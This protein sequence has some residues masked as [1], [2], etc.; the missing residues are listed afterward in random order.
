MMEVVPQRLRPV[1]TEAQRFLL[2]AVLIGVFTGVT[3]VC[4]HSSIELIEWV[5]SDSTTGVVTRLLLPALGAALASF[6]V[7]Y[8]RA[9]AGSGI[10]Q[11][12]SA[13]YVSNGFI[14]FSAVP[15]KFVACVLSIGTGTP[16][17]PEDPALLMGAGIASRL[18]AT[19]G[20]TQRSMRMIAPVGAAAGI[21]AAF[22]TPITGVLFVMEEVMAGWDAAVMGSIVLAA[23]SSVVTTRMFLGESPLFRVP[24][25]AAIGTPREVLVCIALGVAAGIFATLY[26]RGVAL[27]RYRMGAFRLPVAVAPFLAGLAVGAVAMLVPEVLGTGYRAMDSALNNQYTW[28]TMATLA[29]VKLL[30]AGLAFAAGTP[31]GLFAP[32]LFLGVMLGGAFGGLA[33]TALPIGVPSQST[34]ALAGMA[35][36]FAGVFRAPMTAVFMTFELSGTSASILPA[37]ITASLGF[38]VAR[39]FHRQSIL[40]LVAEHEGAVLPSARLARPDEP[41]HVEDALQPLPGTV[42]VRRAT[43]SLAAVVANAPPDATFILVEL[44]RGQWGVVSLDVAREFLAS[45]QDVLLLATRPEWMR[46]S[47]VYSDELL[48]VAIRVLARVP[49]VPVVSRVDDHDLIGVV[50]LADVRRAYRFVETMQAPP[51]PTAEP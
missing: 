42:P 21:A 28:S 29:A 50:T 9:G 16:L 30:V 39:Q 6:V 37:M 19:F 14:P 1:L 20:L 15:G 10:V 45:G 27:L 34:L 11:T 44:P 33:P 12:K 25:V 48:D 4:F 22:N 51:R 36:V 8:I 13:L 31:G 49:I 47:V 46:A 38:L 35:G 17:G 24:E 43:Q 41:L 40:D 32:T 5:V 18:G 3:V 23:V 7:F 2:L 26:V